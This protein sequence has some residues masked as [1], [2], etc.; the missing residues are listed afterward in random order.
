MKNYLKWL[1]F[2]ALLMASPALASNSTNMTCPGA[3]QTFVDQ[4]GTSYTSNAQSIVTAVKGRAILDL[5]QLGCLPASAGTQVNA[6]TDPVSTNDNTQG[7][8]IGSLWVNSTGPKVWVATAVGTGAA[9]WTQTGNSITSG[10]NLQA[11]ASGTAG[12]V[13]IYPATASYGKLALVDNTGNVGAYNATITA[14]NIGQATTYTVPDPG[15]ATASFLLTAGAQ[16]ASGVLTLSHAS[17]ALAV[18]NNETIGGTLVTTGLTTDTGGLVSIVTND[19][20]TPYSTGLTA[21][22]VSMTTYGNC[23]VA[24]VN[25]GTCTP[26]AL[27]TGRTI[28]VTFFDIVA[29]GGNTATC[30]GVLLEDT[31]GTPVVVATLAAATLTANA[32]NIPLTATLG[33]GF[34]AGTGLTASQGLQIKVNGSNCATVTSFQYAITYTVQ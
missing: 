30:T 8:N 4:G 3:N 5:T 21:N 29:L 16:T 27:S 24:A 6:T 2:A 17:T 7:F 1:P 13:D 10:T 31:N 32:H 28:A 25:G 12:E 22:P 20:H 33:V 34:G 18:T 23:T 9:T 11:G 19:F 26:L 15:A 14:G